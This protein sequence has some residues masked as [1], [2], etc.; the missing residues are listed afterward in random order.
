MN[1]QLPII[2]WPTEFRQAGPAS[3]PSI[4]LVGQATIGATEFVVTAIRIN[5]Y[6]T[7]PDYSEAVG[8]RVYERSIANAVDIADFLMDT[9]DFTLLQLEQGSYLLWMVPVEVE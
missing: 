4:L 1:A 5:Q 6:Q 3:D 8:R 7:G 2:N 9:A